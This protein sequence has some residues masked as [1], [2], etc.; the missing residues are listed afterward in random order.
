MEIM[1]AALIGITIY[2]FIIIFFHHGGEY[3]DTIKRR[4]DQVNNVQAKSFQV[5]E[6]INKPLSERFLKPLLKSMA[7]KLSKSKTDD[8]S[9]NPGKSRQMS[10]LK[11]K[12]NQA[13]F[14]ITAAEYSVIR[15]LLILVAA[16]LFAFL[17]LAFG[18]D[19]VSTFFSAA[20]GLFVGYIIMRY[21]LMSAITKRKKLME[22][23]LPDVLDLLS[24]SV[25]AGLGFE[26]AVHHITINMDGPLIDELTVTYREMAMG[27]TRR[28]A[29]VFL[30]NRCDIAEIKTFTAAL[31]QATQ[32]GISMKNVLRSQAASLR[33]ARKTAV[34][35]KAMK[36]SIKML[37][38]L[39]MFIFPV[40]FI[41]LL[42][43][44]IV[45]VLKIFS[46]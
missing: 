21:F 8:D 5:N 24:V 43:P 6:D 9:S 23:Q 13:G 11:K 25:E 18:A 38:P 2:L 22:Q 4:L 7:D 42:G 41:I 46:S 32:L 36:V 14:T 1:I 17:A 45:N 37:F 16:V 27:R 15:L 40:I 19:V 12:L 3:Q 33:L 30:G 35:E 10:V 20:T 26:Q 29:L 31:V 44:A 34:Q 39:V 28:D